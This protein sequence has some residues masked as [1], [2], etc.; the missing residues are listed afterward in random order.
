VPG[1]APEPAPAAAK[2]PKPPPE[3]WSWIGVASQAGFAIAPV[4]PSAVVAVAF[5]NGHTAQP[6]TVGWELPVTELKRT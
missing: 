6:T 4:R 2:R 5:V 3:I 1:T